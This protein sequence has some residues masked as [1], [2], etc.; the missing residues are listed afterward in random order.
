MNGKILKS[1]EREKSRPILI[2][3]ANGLEGS[4]HKEVLTKINQSFK[5]LKRFQ[6]NTVIF[7]Q[8]L[9]SYNMIAI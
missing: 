1:K 7:R 4:M 6:I 2:R 5:D 3:G 9:I 8:A